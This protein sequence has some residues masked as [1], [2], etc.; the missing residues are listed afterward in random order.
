MLVAPDLDPENQDRDFAVDEA[1]DTGSR[2]RL[3]GK[4]GVAVLCGAAV[5]L[6]VTGHSGRGPAAI[7][8]NAKVSGLYASSAAGP[9]SETTAGTATVAS[10]TPVSA[11]SSELAPREDMNDGS[12]C[13]ADEEDF[14]GACFKKC[15]ILSNGE[16]SVRCSAFSC[17][18][19][20]DCSL[21]DTQMNVKMCDGYD[22]AGDAE[23]KGKCPHNEG[24][25]LEDEE[26]HLGMCYKSCAIL[27]HNEYPHR[28]AAMT[29]CKYN[30]FLMCLS[31]ANT[32]TSSDYNVGGGFNDD[33]ESTPNKP[34]P[35][36]KQLAEA[37]AT[38]TSMAP[39]TVAPV[40]PVTP[41]PTAVEPVSTSAAPASTAPS[42]P[43]PVAPV[44]PPVT[45]P[46]VSTEPAVETHALP[47]EAASSS[48]PSS[49]SSDSASSS[50]ESSAEEEASSESYSE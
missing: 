43:A 35:P 1:V 44:A 26:I 8:A 4:I 10:T 17:S 5:V 14:E 42:A 3:V 6:A 13:G 30:K 24:V 15:S 18:K 31:W 47:E 45:D 37:G 46:S 12:L 29:C 32:D 38:D 48:E 19:S 41:A 2:R 16:Y 22:V 7:T 50:S 9:Y 33:D 28:R 40:V 21:M 20:S 25:C 23:G 11:A 34:H 27:T 49:S 36:L 39:V